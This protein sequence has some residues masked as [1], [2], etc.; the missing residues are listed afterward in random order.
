MKLVLSLKYPSA[1]L[2]LP[3]CEGVCGC[4]GGSWRVVVLH[5]QRPLPCFGKCLTNP[6]IVTLNI[7]IV[8][9]IACRALG[10][11]FQSLYLFLNLVLG[12]KKKKDS[13]ELQL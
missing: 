9:H 3:P 7:L 6:S 10:C 13:S 1:F 8:V 4:S 11:S 12:V 2:T 5:V